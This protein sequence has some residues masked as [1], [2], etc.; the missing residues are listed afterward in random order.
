MFDAVAAII[1]F[2]RCRHTPPPPSRH[3]HTSPA[4]AAAT[5]RRWYAMPMP[6]ILLMP[7]VDK[8]FFALLMLSLPMI[9]AARA[10]RRRYIDEDFFSCRC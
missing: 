1:T 6:A 5:I 9:Y 4:A 7:V 2:R 3:Y 8:R 10:T